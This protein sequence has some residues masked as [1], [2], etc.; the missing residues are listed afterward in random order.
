MINTTNTK[1]K[2]NKIVKKQIVLLKKPISLFS[3]FI[4]VSFIFFILF[5]GLIRHKLEIIITISFLI[6]CFIHIYISVYKA[7]IVITNNKFYYY[8]NKNKKYECHY[9]NDFKFLNY[10]KNNINKLLN[11]GT[12]IFINQRKEIYTIKYVPDVFNVYE[13][14]ILSYEDY[15]LFKNPQYIKTYIKQESNIDKIEDN[16]TNEK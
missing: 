16:E 6:F 4:P 9:I 3:Y 5:Y 13:K 1:E 10:E 12:L 11:F 7:K 14:I 2:S 15:Q 8:V